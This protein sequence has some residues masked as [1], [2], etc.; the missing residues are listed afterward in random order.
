MNTSSFEIMLPAPATPH[1]YEAVDEP[2]DELLAADE[3]VLRPQPSKK[4]ATVA[5]ERSPHPPGPNIRTPVPLPKT[6]AAPRGRSTSQPRSGAS[7]PGSRSGNKGRPKGWKPGMSYAA[8]RNFG[9]EVAAQ[10]AAMKKGAN[11]PAG[12]AKLARAGS[13][14]KTPRAAAPA[15]GTQ[16]VK[17]PKA[18]PAA[19]QQKLMDIYMELGV[20]GE[21]FRCEWEGCQSQLHNLNTLKRHVVIV[22]CRGKRRECLWRRCA[23]TGITFDTDEELAEHLGEEHFI[24]YAWHL[25]DGPKISF[26]IPEPDLK[27]LP[28]YLFDK[29]GNQVTDSI[30]GQAV[31]DDATRGVRE[32]ALKEAQLHGIPQVPFELDSEDEDEK[33]VL[34]WSTP[35]P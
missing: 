32:A 16:A 25:G 20:K 9:P 14:R 7:T 4:L 24:P 5:R 27:A 17:P 3:L 29:A 30:Q 23:Y 34:G 19:P 33:M 2:E 21:P 12:T 6:T 31:E 22:H 13:R 10:Y 18:K 28:I 11:R 8:V 35:Y 26:G 1:Q 15:P